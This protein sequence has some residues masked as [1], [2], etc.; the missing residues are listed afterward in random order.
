MKRPATHAD[1]PMPQNTPALIPHE[2]ESER[3]AESSPLHMPCVVRMPMASATGRRPQKA[4]YES[5]D[6][7][8]AS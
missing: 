8:N 2:A 1:G 3:G 7:P 4:F 6:T 5:D